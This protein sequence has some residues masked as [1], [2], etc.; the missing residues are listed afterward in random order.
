MNRFGRRIMQRHPRVR[1]MTGSGPA[2]AGREPPALVLILYLYIL[3]LTNRSC[4]YIIRREASKNVSTPLCSLPQPTHL[5]SKSRTK[6]DLT[7]W[8]PLDSKR[9]SSTALHLL[10][11]DL[12]L[13]SSWPATPRPKT[14]I[15]LLLETDGSTTIHFSPTPTPTPT[16]YPNPRYVAHCCN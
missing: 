6:L 4:A 8:V 3:P 11:P 1:T 14:N 12:D 13:S 7:D 15:S 2:K 5:Y 16:Y 9:H 10:M